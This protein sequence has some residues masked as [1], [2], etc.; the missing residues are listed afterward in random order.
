MQLMLTQPPIDISTNVTITAVFDPPVIAL[1]GKSTYRVTVNAV[2][3][4]VRWPED[5]LAPL[6]LTLRPSARGQIL[7]PALDKIRPATT[8]NHHVTATKSGTFT[9]PEFK[10]RVY[11]N[12]VTVPAAHLEVVPQLNPGT[13]PPSRL[14]L[15]LAATNV[16]CGQPIKIQIFMPST[17][18]NAIQALSLV[19]VN[20][21][22]V[23]LD[24]SVVRQRIQ[25]MERVNRTAGTMRFFS[26]TRDD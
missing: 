19:Q 14:Y 10:L 8:I 11:G 5:I 4:S 25:Q 20:G 15:Q 13:P 24:Q 7:Q 3:D 22:G 17:S 21:D 2:S 9:I 6:E 18:G 26:V 12:L 23:L 16:Y 1:G